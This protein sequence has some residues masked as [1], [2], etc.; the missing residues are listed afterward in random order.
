MVTSSGERLEEAGPE[1]GQAE[2]GA[3][4][5]LAPEHQHRAHGEQG[6]R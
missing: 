1:H 3:Q 6:Q 5:E 2:H 4:G